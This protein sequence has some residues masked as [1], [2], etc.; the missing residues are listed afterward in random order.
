MLHFLFSNPADGNDDAF[1]QMMK[2]FVQ[3]NRNASASTEDFFSMAS[4]HFARTPIAKKYGLKDL[5]WFSRQWVYEAGMP[6]YR[7]E[8]EFTA[9]PEGGVLLSGTVFQEGVPDYWIMPLPLLLDFGGG[10]GARGTVIAQG[11]QTPFKIGLP[12]E[13]KRVLLDPD[14]WVLASKESESRVKH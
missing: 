1:Y 10:K 3:A 9:R 12:A 11:P 14:L 5:N 2:D 13:P 8:Y 6:S 7:L 4:E